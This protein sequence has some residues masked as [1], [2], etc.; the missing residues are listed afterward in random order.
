VKL[1]SLTPIR[2]L[3][4]VADTVNGFIKLAE[5][6]KTT[7]MTVNTG[8]GRGVTIG[9]LAELIIERVNPDASIVCENERVRPSNS[10]VMQLICDN[11]RAQKLA[12]WKPAYALEKGL[13]LTIDW[14]REHISAYKT[15]LYTI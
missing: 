13:S 5:S 6:N 2:D 9:E 12:G 10:E 7:G 1:G 8:S 11:R 4:Y 14:M 3:T 15:G